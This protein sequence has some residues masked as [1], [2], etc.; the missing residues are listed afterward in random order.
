MPKDGKGKNKKWSK[1]VE[2]DQG[3]DRLA[4]MEEKAARMGVEVWQLKDLEE[5]EEEEEEEEKVKEQMKEVEKEDS[6]E[7]EED[8]D[9]EVVR[10]HRGLINTHNPNHLKPLTKSDFRTE[11]EMADSKKALKQKANSQ[12][13]DLERLQEVRARREAAAKLITSIQLRM[14]FPPIAKKCATSRRNSCCISHPTQQL[15]STFAHV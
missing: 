4:E 12:T 7:E 3:F 10:G 8:D 15:L 6:E 1:H 9:S 5:E 14:G 2:K 11:E 13:S